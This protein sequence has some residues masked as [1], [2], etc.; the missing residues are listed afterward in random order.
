[1]KMALDY[2]PAG[3]VYESPD[4]SVG[5][6]GGWYHDEC[7]LGDAQDVTMRMFVSGYVG[8]GA[9]RAAV[10]CVTLECSCGAVVVFDHQEW[11]PDDSESED[12]DETVA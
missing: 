1:M 12:Q 6:P 3:W 5:L 2:A 11:D 8:D 4:M 9:N 10:L 7:A